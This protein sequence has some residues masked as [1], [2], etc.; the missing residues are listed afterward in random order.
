MKLE[1]VTDFVEA[2]VPPLCRNPCIEYHYPT[3][4]VTFHQIPENLFIC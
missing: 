1:E 3:L 4:P 2:W